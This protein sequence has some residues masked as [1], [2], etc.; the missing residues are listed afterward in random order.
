MNVPIDTN[1]IIH[2]V[3]QHKDDSCHVSQY[4]VKRGPLKQESVEAELKS[5]THAKTFAVPVCSVLIIIFALVSG[6]Q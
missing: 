4:W 1:G 3:T 6:V 5:R 2:G